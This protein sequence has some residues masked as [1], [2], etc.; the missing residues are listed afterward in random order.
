MTDAPPVSRASTE[1]KMTMVELVARAIYAAQKP[2]H[3]AGWDDG[4]CRIEGNKE[5]MFGVARIAIQAMM[6]PTEAMEKA[7]RIHVKIEPGTA[8]MTLWTSNRWQAM[9]TAALEEG[10]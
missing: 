9:L 3:H 5:F 8:E 6:T 10:E 7:G 1:R 2:N 4:F